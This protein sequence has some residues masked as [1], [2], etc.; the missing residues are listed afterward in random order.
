MNKIDYTKYSIDELFQVKN[1]MDA[2]A[3]PDTYH[4]VMNE[5][6]S[7]KS[8]IKHNKIKQ[9]KAK[10]ITVEKHVKIIG[11]LQIAAALVIGFLLIQGIV[12]KF[13]TSFWTISITALLVGLNGF[14]GYTVIREM[15]RWY[16]VSIFNQSLQLFNIALGSTVMN[17]SG[18]AG[19]FISL[20]WGNVFGLDFSTGFTPGFEYQ[21]YPSVISPNYVAVDIFA[22]IFIVALLTV[23]SDRKAKQ[24][25][26]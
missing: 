6:E 20:S 26:I 19:F 3:Y 9:E 5:L 25:L 10:Y 22:V 13:E 11:Y 2:I 7:R 14:A 23:K 4:E 1:G 18:L 12:T 8:E 15:K 17:Y 21:V 24:N 16:W